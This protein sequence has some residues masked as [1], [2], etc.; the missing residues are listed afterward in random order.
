M[1]VWVW[2]ERNWEREIEREREREREHEQREKDRERAKESINGKGE[3]E[4]LVEQNRY[5]VTMQWVHQIMTKLRFYMQH[6]QLSNAITRSYWKHRSIIMYL[7]YE[8]KIHTV[9]NQ[10]FCRV[11]ITHSLLI[12]DIYNKVE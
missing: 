2:R 6:S 9:F 5:N 8:I 3:K 11:H 12:Y 7:V 10:L 1:H 4:L